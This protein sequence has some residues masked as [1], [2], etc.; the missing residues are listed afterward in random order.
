MKNVFYRA[1]KYLKY[2]KSKSIILILMFFIICNILLISTSINDTINDYYNSIENKNGIS[3]SVN[4]VM[5]MEKGQPNQQEA[6]NSSN[7]STEEINEKIAELDYI[8]DILETKTTMITSLQIEAVENEES[9]SETLQENSNQ[10]TQRANNIDMSG[11]K[12]LGS[13]NLILEQ[14]YQNGKIALSSGSLPENNNE[15][16]ISANLAKLN[17]LELNDQIKLSDS[18]EE[19]TQKFKVVGIYQLENETS[20]FEKMMIPDNTIYTTFETLDNFTSNSD[21]QDRFQQATTK[22]YIKSIDNFEHFKEDYYQI[23]NTSSDDIEISLNDDVYQST[24]KPLSELNNNLNYLKWGVLITAISILGIVS[25]IDVKNR[26]REIGILYSMSESKRKI[27][28][29]FVFENTLLLTIAFVIALGISF[30]SMDF[31]INGLM[32]MSIFDSVNQGANMMQGGPPNQLVDTSKSEINS[33]ISLLNLVGLYLILVM[34]IAI[35][36][37]LVS[38][39]ALKRRVKD[40]INE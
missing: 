14:D 9:S 21:E 24:I 36:I 5:S 3:I 23:T 27:F 19:N 35:I 6:S 37:G 10:A 33:S 4:K 7:L 25:Y 16:M 8:S 34:V 13:S 11:L 2:K 20:G 18:N 31:I 15:V 28:A 32:N 29:Q 30:I 39:K 22:Y 40:I 12:L 17:E 38:Y 26:Q 1:R